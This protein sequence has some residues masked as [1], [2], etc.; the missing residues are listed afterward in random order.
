[1]KPAVRSRAPFVGLSHLGKVA[2]ERIDFYL[3]HKIYTHESD[4]SVFR[5][6]FPHIFCYACTRGTQSCCS[7]HVFIASFQSAFLREHAYRGTIYGC[8]F[9]LSLSPL[10]IGACTY[11]DMC[12][13]IVPGAGEA[14][15]R[16]D[17]LTAVFAA[18]VLTVVNFELYAMNTVC[19]L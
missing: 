14:S 7:L 15:R 12:T 18:H 8:N 4:L 11:R 1:M 3:F 5:A 6:R 10:L 17:W 16:A 2:H 9:F 19:V 13:A